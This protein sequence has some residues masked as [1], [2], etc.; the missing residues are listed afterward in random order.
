MSTDK[1]DEQQIEYQQK[2][3]VKEMLKRFLTHDLHAASLEGIIAMGMGVLISEPPISIFHD[4]RNFHAKMGL[5]DCMKNFTASMQQFRDGILKE[6]FEEYQ[7]AVLLKNKEKQLDALIDIIYVAAG[8][9]VMHGW[10]GEEAW[11]R[12][13]NAN[14]K[15]VPGQPGE[16]KQ[17]AQDTGE[18]DILKPEGWKAPKM[19]DLL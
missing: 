12:V 11:R 19:Q 8:T 14:M 1:L 2:Q 9:I 16:G 6:E 17:V 10:D 15:K 5:P 7:D 13:H 4:V 18:V 3:A